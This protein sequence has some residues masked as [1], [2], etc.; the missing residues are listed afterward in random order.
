MYRLDLSDFS[1]QLIST[2]G[3]G[4]QTGIS[5]HT[6]SLVDDNGGQG[7]AIEVVTKDGKRYLLR[8]ED[9]KWTE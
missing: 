7:P 4:P 6:A 3:A 8:L 2:S 5:E 9:M 1:I